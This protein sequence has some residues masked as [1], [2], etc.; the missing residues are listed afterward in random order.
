MVK[1]NIQRVSERVKC[2]L[3]R[4]I[5]SMG[6]YMYVDRNQQLFSESEL[7]AFRILHP[8]AAYTEFGKVTVC[9]M[10][11]FEIERKRAT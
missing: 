1:Y 9:G 6:T 4:G 2:Y 7:E 8:E 3:C 11:R 10:C 5:D